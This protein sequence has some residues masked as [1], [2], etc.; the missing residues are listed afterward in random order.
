MTIWLMTVLASVTPPM[1]DP[2]APPGVSDAVRTLMSWLRWGV[3]IAA[4][5]ALLAGVIMWVAGS[6]QSD[7]QLT[8][9]GK[10]AAGTGAIAGMIS[11]FLPTI[12]NQLFS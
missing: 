12:V 9:Y 7:Y 6:T 4:G 8:K 10:R 11:P 2:Q 3:P 5:I 1:P